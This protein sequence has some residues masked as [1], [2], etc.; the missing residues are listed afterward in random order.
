MTYCLDTSAW[1]EYLNAGTHGPTIKKLLEAETEVLTPAIVVAQVIE[2]ARRRRENSKTFLEFLQSRTTIAPITAEIARL[3]GKVNA[4]RSTSDSTWTM[5]ESLIL[6]TARHYHARLVT[7][8]P[9]F[10][11]IA[12]V[13]LLPPAIGDV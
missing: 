3:A 12:Q 7:S 6:A 4:T 11:G 2:A 8:D 5:F 10:A 13:D 1:L 9:I